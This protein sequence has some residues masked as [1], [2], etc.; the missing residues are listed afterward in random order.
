MLE[1]SRAL[2]I[3]QRQQSVARKQ[4]KYSGF[5]VAPNYRCVQEILTWLKHAQVID[6]IATL[7]FL[8]TTLVLSGGESMRVCSIGDLIQ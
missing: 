5:L 4:S 1:G 6:F 7:L 2:Q 3:L 8:V